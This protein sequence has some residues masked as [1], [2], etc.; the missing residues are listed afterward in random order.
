MFPQKM[1]LVQS[2]QEVD[3]VCIHT[4]QCCITYV[5]THAMVDVFGCSINNGPRAILGLDVGECVF[6]DTDTTTETRVC[7]SVPTTIV[8]FENRFDLSPTKTR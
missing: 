7:K 1:F 5:L 2:A 8:R 3:V 4:M 6:T